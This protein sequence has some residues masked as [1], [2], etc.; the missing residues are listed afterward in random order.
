MIEIDITEEMYYR[1]SARAEAALFN[2]N[3][4]LSQYTKLLHGFLG[5]EAVK[6]VTGQEPLRG[7]QKGRDFLIDDQ[8]YEVKTRSI[9]KLLI[10]PNYS[11]SVY[12]KS[13]TSDYYIFVFLQKNLK[14]AAVVGSLPV[15]EFNKK[16]KWAPRGKEGW[17]VLVSDVEEWNL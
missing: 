3:N 5:E 14:T 11:V 6:A 13:T 8:Y 10:Y 1:A 2:F 9:S 12:S 7:N 4:S 16:A 17:E 15:Q